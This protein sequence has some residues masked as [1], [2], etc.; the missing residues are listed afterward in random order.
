MDAFS[1]SCRAFKS[2]FYFFV[3]ALWPDMFEFNGSREIEE[4][5]SILI[6]KRRKL[7]GGN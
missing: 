4:L 2:G 6:Y 7:I 1:Y 5:N 3:H